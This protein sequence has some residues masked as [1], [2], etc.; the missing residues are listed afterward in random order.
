MGAAIH[1][2]YILDYFPGFNNRRVRVPRKRY[3]SDRYTIR[4]KD[5]LID[6]PYTPYKIEKV[7]IFSKL[8]NTWQPNKG[9]YVLKIIVDSTNAI[10]ETNE[11]NNTKTVSFNIW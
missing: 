3:S 10:K 5:F 7:A 4:D 2:K 9:R 1:V 6:Y 8:F 11:N